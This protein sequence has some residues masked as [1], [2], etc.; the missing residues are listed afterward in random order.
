LSGLKLAIAIDNC[1]R[2]NEI[3]AMTAISTASDSVLLN[4]NG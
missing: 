3:P 2:E 4:S 1:R